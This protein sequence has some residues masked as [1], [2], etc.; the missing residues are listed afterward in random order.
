MISAVFLLEGYGIHTLML[1]L[2]YKVWAHA[3]I[4]RSA[5]CIMSQVPV[6]CYGTLMG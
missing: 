4:Y 1:Q 6:A 5:T 2:C 3:I